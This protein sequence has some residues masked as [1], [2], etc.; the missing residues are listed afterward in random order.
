MITSSQMFLTLSLSLSLRLQIISQRKL[1]KALLRPGGTVGKAII[2]VSLP[3]RPL[4][5]SSSV[6]RCSDALE[7]SHILSSSCPLTTVSSLSHHLL[8][9]FLL[10]SSRFFAL[11]LLTTVFLSSHRLLMFFPSMSLGVCLMSQLDRQDYLFS[12]HAFH[13]STNSRLDNPPLIFFFTSVLTSVASWGFILKGFL[14]RKQIQGFYFLLS[15]FHMF[16]LFFI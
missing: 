8:P 10:S 12:S 3:V 11:C 6:H 5:S 1:S 2:T 4:S 7:L 15:I 14:S 9:M 16:F 13:S